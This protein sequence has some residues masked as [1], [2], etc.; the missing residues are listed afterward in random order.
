MLAKNRQRRKLPTQRTMMTSR[1]SLLNKT[2]Y[3]DSNSYLYDVAGT[4]VSHLLD[5]L[6]LT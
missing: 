6:D 5:K 1:T 3:I 4:R 2:S